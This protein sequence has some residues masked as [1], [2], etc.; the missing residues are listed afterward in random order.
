MFC[1]LF[2]FFCFSSFFI[3]IYI[4]YLTM[5]LL[6]MLLCFMLWPIALF[7]VTSLYSAPSHSQPPTFCGPVLRPAVF[8]THLFMRRESISFCLHIYL[9]PT[10]QAL[11]ALWMRRYSTLTEVFLF[12]FLHHLWPLMD[13]SADSAMLLIIYLYILFA[14]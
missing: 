10:A 5:P 14:F 11:V 13:I 1:F 3:Y 6:A 7:S 8:H 2:L 4:G 12:I 9:S